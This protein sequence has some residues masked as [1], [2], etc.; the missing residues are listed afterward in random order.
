M[1]KVF[2]DMVTPVK[3]VAPFILFIILA[4]NTTFSQPVKIIFDT[5]MA[6]DVDDV[7]AL[8]ILNHLSDLGECEILA[9]G[10]ST[11][12]NSYDG[13]Y[14]ASCASAVNG[15]YD[16]PDIPV[17][18]YRGPYVIINDVSRY[19]EKVSKSFPHKLANGSETEDAFRLYRKILS[20][21]PDSSVV[22]V[23]VGF[24]TNLDLLLDSPPDEISPLSGYDLISRKVKFVSCM[25]GRFPDGWEEFNLNTYPRSTIM[26]LSSWPTPVVY[27]GFELGSRV[28]CG[29]VLNERFKK[30]ENPVAMAWFYY[31][32]GENRE[33]WDE[34]SALYAVKGCAGYF[35]LSEPGTCGFRILGRRNTQ[36]AKSK[37]SWT[38]DPLGKDHY[39]IPVMSYE[40]LGNEL[41]K[42]LPSTPLRQ[43]E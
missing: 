9:V 11:P 12:V 23:V 3:V 6:Q 18:G 32:G 42:M 1:L 28:K 43:R 19:V 30:E 21:Q 14:A 40:Q 15:Y 22:I 10:I 37:N 20:K 31:T 25:G 41:D 8:A 38:P 16:R 2:T 39:L 7:G 27:G 5:D 26:V 17:G 13:Y 29:K 24:L 36:S 34:L 33:S 35:K 4:W